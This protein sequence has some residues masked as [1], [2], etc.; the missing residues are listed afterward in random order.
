MYIK[1]TFFF[2]WVIIN[3]EMHMFKPVVE[4]ILIS[5]M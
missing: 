2:M 4:S 1:I 3:Y 5:V